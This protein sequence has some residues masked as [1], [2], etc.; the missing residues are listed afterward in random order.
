MN[1]F[2]LDSETYE[3]IFGDEGYL[4]EIADILGI[5]DEEISE[6]ENV[7]VET[8][9]KIFHEVKE[10]SEELSEMSLQL[11]GA[12]LLIKILLHAYNE[13]VERFQKFVKEKVKF[14]NKIIMIFI[15]S[16]LEII[17]ILK[18]ILD[19]KA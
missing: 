16:I 7:V 19:L 11:K 13:R 15:W 12:K 10:L 4:K 17:S 14:L 6:N 5:G 8:V 2:I 1:N 3:E 18:I 9:T